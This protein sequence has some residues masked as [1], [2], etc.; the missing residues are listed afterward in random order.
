LQ[1]IQGLGTPF[2]STADRDVLSSSSIHLDHF[3]ENPRASRIF[4]KLSQ[5]TESR[6]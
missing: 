6:P 4:N 2:T 1:S 3:S 5:F